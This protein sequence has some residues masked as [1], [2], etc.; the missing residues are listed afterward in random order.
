MGNPVEFSMIE[1]AELV[2]ELTGSRSAMIR[3]PLPVDDP[4][5]RCPDITQAKEKLGWEPK[6]PLRE[7]LI[8]TI[9][10]FDALL[11]KQAA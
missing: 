3:L 7:G 4:K 2:L 10:H 9:A 5:H 6:V 11:S 8:R 1:L